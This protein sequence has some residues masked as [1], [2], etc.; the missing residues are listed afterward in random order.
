MDLNV[1]RTSLIK[2]LEQV[3]DVSLLKTVKVM[4]QYRLKKESRITI[5]KYNRELK[6]AEARI[7]AGNFYTQDEVETMAKKW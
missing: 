5:A 1:E 4:L 3:D 7:D 2:D 6:E